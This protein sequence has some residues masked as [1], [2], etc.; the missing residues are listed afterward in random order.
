MLTGKAFPPYLSFLLPSSL[1]LHTA[2][3][4][5]NIK[6]GGDIVLKLII[7]LPMLLTEFEYL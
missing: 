5:A 2:K 7:Q 3:R 1:S 6:N 4:N